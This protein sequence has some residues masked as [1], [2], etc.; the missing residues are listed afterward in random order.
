[1]QSLTLGFLEKLLGINFL[2]KGFHKDL[3]FYILTAPAGKRKKKKKSNSFSGFCVFT[4]ILQL[5]EHH[6]SINQSSRFVVYIF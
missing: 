4:H 1:M 2:R 6:K 3:S 5:P